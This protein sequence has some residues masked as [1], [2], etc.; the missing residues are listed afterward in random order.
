MRGTRVARRRTVCHRDQQGA[1]AIKNPLECALERTNS[2]IDPADLG[3]YGFDD[4]A[5]GGGS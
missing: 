2:A 1:C 4:T 5:R 3:T